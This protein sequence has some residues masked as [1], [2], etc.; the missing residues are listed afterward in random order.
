[1][2]T[3]PSH[4]MTSPQIAKPRGLVYVVDDD[5]A[6]RDSMRWLLEGNSFSVRCFADAES[7]LRTLPQ[8]RQP[9]CLVLDVR[10]PGMSGI[11]LHEKLLS[12]SV[13]VPV[14]FVTGH[15]D[16]P[17]AVESMKRGA[18]DFLEKPFN[19]VELCSLIDKALQTAAKSS[20]E[21][22]ALQRAQNVYEKLSTRER[23]VLALIVKGRLNKQIADDLS[24]SIKTVEAHRA[25]IMDKMA[26][27]NMAELM[28]LA[29]RVI[30]L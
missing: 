10:M 25:N 14:I 9:V 22:G 23:E 7:L 27:R 18:V 26:A 30:A 8:E 15:G 16:V 24:I 13:Q 19:D 1:V 4:L 12:Q 17:M 11:E 20:D 21:S 2:N 5:D 6:V 28:K 3:S 29:L